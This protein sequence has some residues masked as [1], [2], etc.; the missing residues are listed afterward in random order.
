[1]H[2]RYGMED[3]NTDLDSQYH[4]FKTHGPLVL[5][6]GGHE[7]AVTRGMSLWFKCGRVCV[8]SLD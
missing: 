2:K 1:M 7:T 6:L 4:I 3:L 8:S 5:E